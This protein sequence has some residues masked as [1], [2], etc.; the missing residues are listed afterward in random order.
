MVDPDWQGVGIGNM[1]H[2]VSSSYAVEHKAH[3]FSAD[4]LVGNSAM[5]R[6]FQRGGDDLTVTTSGVVRGVTMIFREA[7]AGVHEASF[8]WYR[9]FIQAQRSGLEVAWRASA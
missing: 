7:V 3:G 4:V 1:L 6:V 5:L 8:H 2:T 9:D